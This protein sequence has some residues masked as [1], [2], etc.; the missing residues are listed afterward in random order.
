MSAMSDLAVAV[1]GHVHLREPHRD[2]DALR[3][4]VRN[5]ARWAGPSSR[6]GVLMLAEATGEEA[7]ARL[8]GGTGASRELPRR[9]TTEPESVWFEVDG[10]RLLV[11]AG[12]QVVTREGLEVLALATA[13]RLDDGRPLADTLSAV[14]EADAVAV[15]PW[16]CGKW[17]GARRRLVAQ[18]LRAS[19]GPPLLLG[20]NGN[21][22]A[23]WH[24][25]W[26]AHDRPV[27][28]GTD[29]LPLPG[30]WQ[31][32]GRF[33]SVIPVMPGQA[34]PAADLR[35]ALRDP[36]VRLP[37]YGPHER[38]GRFVLGQMRLRLGRAETSAVPA[39]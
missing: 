8:H 28:R 29:P 16:G 37:P 34:R 25:P 33:G 11:V 26:L 13:A 12:R 35:R 18:T 27:L 4:A 24:E 10:W 2:A 32:I 21:R 22:P 3:T 31:Q 6:V 39:A 7:F 19:D 30:Q 20:D 14:H 17:T 38:L 9:L 23:A 1:D 36:A 15:L 5:F